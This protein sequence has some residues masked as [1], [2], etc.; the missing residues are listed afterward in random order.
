MNAT[1]LIAA[2][3]VLA[4]STSVFAQSPAAKTRAEVRAEV[5]QAQDA[6]INLSGGEGYQS[7]IT[8]VSSKTRDAV[9]A[10]YVAAKRAGEILDGEQY[11]TIGNVVSTKS[12]A[13]VQAEFLQARELGQIRQE[14]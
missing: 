5:L 11:G 2:A 1:K 9:K 13:Q 10:E 7:D 3:A 4:L 8:F 6:G 12:R 14:N